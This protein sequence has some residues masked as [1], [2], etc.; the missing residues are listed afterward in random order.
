MRDRAAS[1]A[2]RHGPLTARGARRRPR[3]R[4]RRPRRRLHGHVVRRHADKRALVPGRADRADRADGSRLGRVRRRGRGA[5][6]RDRALP[7]RGL[8]RPDLGSAR[9]RH[10]GRDGAGRQRGLRGTRR[11]GAARLDRDAPGGAARQARRP[12]RG[13]GR[14]LVRR[15]DPARHGGDRQARRRDHAADR[16]ALARDQPLSGLDPQARLVRPALPGRRQR[17]PRPAHQVGVRPGPGD[18]SARRRH[19]GAGSPRAGPARS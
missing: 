16:L 18:R 3:P 5:R 17:S 19:A 8:Q 1:M 6:R 2:R 11:P 13:H 10:V 9:L 4:P 14:R 15:R 12:A 7:R